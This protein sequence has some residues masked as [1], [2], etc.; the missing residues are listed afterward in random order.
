MSLAQ[1][2]AR[3]TGGRR[4]QVGESEVLHLSSTPNAVPRARQFVTGRLQGAGLEQYRD[5]AELAVAELV[6]NAL[7]HAAPPVSLRVLPQDDKVRVEVQDGSRTA[8]SE[9]RRVGKECR[10]RWSPYH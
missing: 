4:R 10:S 3:G 5:D 8:R 6:T 2:R 7:L 1:S 9:E